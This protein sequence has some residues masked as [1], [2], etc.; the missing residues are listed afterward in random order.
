MRLATQVGALVRH[1]LAPDLYYQNGAKPKAYRRLARE[2]ESANATMELLL[3]VATADHF[4]RTTED[5]L[6]RVYPAG[7]WFQSQLESLDIEKA[8]PRDAVLGRHLLAR[9]LSPGPRIGKTLERCRE[10]QDKTGLSDPQQIL[11]RVLGPAPE[12]QDR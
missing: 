7:D 12:K 5:A 8:A 3:R 6:A 2:L 10:V 1:H 9:G 4:G 11:D